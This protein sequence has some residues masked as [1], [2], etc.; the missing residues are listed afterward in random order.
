MKQL[1]V[2]LGVWCLLTGAAYASPANG[3]WAAPGAF[4]TGVWTE[5]FAGGGP[6]QTGNVIT[7]VGT[8]WSLT[9]ATLQ[10][11]PAPVVD[12]ALNPPYLWNTPYING[13]L[14]LNAGGPWDGGGTSVVNM[15]PLTV[16]SSGTS[17]PN[18]QLMWTMSGSG[19]VSGSGQTV[20]LTASFNGTPSP[21]M[22]PTG[23]IVGMTGQITS[24]TITIVPAP[25]AIL[26]GVLGT[27]VVGWLRR[28]RSL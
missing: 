25:G 5:S 23:G 15:G 24:A 26:L 13:V 12:P 8:Q 9:N 19:V 22:G 4:D 1:L 16:Y 27:G 6:G 14:T 11:P 17:L 3:T 18:N 28:R 21:L 7:A 10:G 20:F 2:A